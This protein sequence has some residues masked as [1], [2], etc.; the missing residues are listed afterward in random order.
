MALVLP[1][2]IYLALFGRELFMQLDIIR[3]ILVVIIFNI[4][5]IISTFVLYTVFEW[6]KEVLKK[7]LEIVLYKYMYIKKDEKDM[8]D[9]D[10]ITKSFNEINKIMDLS[11]SNVIDSKNINNSKLIFRVIVINIVITCLFLA[12][13]IIKFI[14]NKPLYYRDDTRGLLGVI[15]I[16]YIGCCILQFSDLII[17]IKYINEQKKTIK[18][19][20]KL[21]KK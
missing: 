11:V 4:C 6:C 1:S 7:D 5:L 9:S 12:A 8:G 21:D 19:I 20:L 2:F 10:E 16:I 14:L 3:L 17:N 13:Y 15:I 18:R